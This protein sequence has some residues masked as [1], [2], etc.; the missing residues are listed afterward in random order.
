MSAVVT[1][2]RDR[3]G[4]EITAA[5]P[6]DFAELE[7]VIRRCRPA[8]D[9]DA[10]PLLK[11]ARFGEITTGK[12]ALRHDG[13]VLEVTGVEGD[14]DGEAI[15]MEH[16]AERLSAA[17]VAA[18]LY[19]S[20]SHTPER[21]RWRVIVALSQPLAGT[22][23]EL[24]AQRA[25]WCG[26]L[27]AIL[28]GI[29]SG[30]SFVLSQCFYFGPIAGKPEPQIIRLSGVCLDQ[31]ESPPAPQ[32]P[33]EAHVGAAHAEGDQGRT[34][35][36]TPDLEA[37]A[38]G[39]HV[40][41]PTLRLTARYVAKGLPP[42]EA[43]EL[44]RAVLT[45]HREVWR[46]KSALWQECFDQ[47]SRYAE[48][49]AR[50]FAPE[51]SSWS[52]PLNLFARLAAPPYEAESA[53]AVL[54]DYAMAYAR[55]T[56][57]DPSITLGAAIATAA[58]ALSDGFSIVADSSSGWLQSARLWVLH[59]GP[60][61][62]GKSPGQKAMAAP[63]WDIHGEL[64]AEHAKC[65]ATLGEDDDKPPRPRAIVGDT[66]IEALAEVLRDCPRGVLTIADE[67]ESWLGSMDVYRSKGG[68]SRDRGEWLRLFDGGPHTVERVQR[69][70]MY[71][72]NWGVSIL[73]ASTPASM[74]KLT[75]QLP[76]DG[77]LQRFIPIIAGRQVVTSG[78]VHALEPL[79]E[80]YGRTIRRLWHASPRA[81]N[82]AVPLSQAAAVYFREWRAENQRL[83]EAMGSIAP[84]LESHVAKYPTLLL[85]LTLVYHCAKIVNLEHEG[86][87]DP[88]AWPVPVETM[89]EAARFLRTASRHAI[90]LY[91][92]TGGGS[93]AFELA[94]SIARAVLAKPWE[95]VERRVL[96]QSVRAFREAG[97]YHQDV[98]LRLLVD[99]GWLRPEDSGYEKARPTRYAI[100]PD[101]R[102]LFAAEA[103]AE[104]GRRAVLREAIAD[105]VSA[106]R[107]DR[108]G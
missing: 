45:R 86:A 29:L 30:E 2:W 99:Y 76:E 46:E 77:L 81:H 69:G 70:S 68:A 23:E 98:A 62:A 93:E 65:L 57:I 73:T 74:A 91:A 51:P 61:G 55:H 20:A 1:V 31:I 11:L 28:G 72:P 84:A 58:G 97:E 33:A 56:G 27:N 82:G 87:R 78:A 92:G 9:K 39:A 43:A 4:T 35:A 48:D 32:I 16:A 25:H 71:V 7:R 75:R 95:R 24:R 13:N 59:I 108:E 49:A 47:A 105:A 64:V 21:P 66:T 89:L 6:M 83:Q 102:A 8:A 104:K 26:V 37:I 5:R 60:P 88:A 14:Y 3:T 38:T 79:R 18:L 12:R 90:A 19:T 40:R 96:A 54:A 67:F 42:P 52:A 17:G 15:P 22:A 103:E 106:R 80:A 10:L 41:G 100:N 85:R 107:S 44:V 94:R 101:A 53:P 34:T 50:K 36:G 63:L